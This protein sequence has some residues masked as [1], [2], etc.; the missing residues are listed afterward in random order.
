MCPKCKLENVTLYMGGQFGKYQCKDCG[1]IGPLILDKHRKIK[2]KPTRLAISYWLSICLPAFV[3]SIG[4]FIL[5]GIVTNL[6]QN[7]FFIRMTNATIWDYIFL[8]L[9]SVLLGAYTSLGLYQRKH[10]SKICNTTAY[11][12]GVA[13]FLGFSCPVCNK[14]LVLLLGVTGVLT[15][16][17]P[18]R[19]LIGSIGIGLMGYAVYTKGKYVLK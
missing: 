12:G 9:T 1:Y 10:K 6:I 4:F 3:Y 15:Y 14:I 5:F 16:I 2:R 11:S 18:Y 7:K 8:I 13:G 19:P 17:E